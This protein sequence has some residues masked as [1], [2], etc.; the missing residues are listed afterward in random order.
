M[1]D[2][3]CGARG[4]VG[5]HQISKPL[6]S[7]TLCSVRRGL[8]NCR[9]RSGRFQ[10]PLLAAVMST[11]TAVSAAANDG[12]FDIGGG[13]RMYLE[14]RGSGSPTVVL[15]AGLKASADD[16][17]TAAKPGPAVFS[18]VANLTRVCAYDRP[19]TPVGGQAS[20]SDPVRQPT[21]AA[22]AVADLRALLGAA[23][24]AAP[25]VLVGHSYGGLI[26]TLYARFY[27]EAVAGLVLVDA[28]SEG[29]QQAEAPNQWAVQRVLL[30]GD[31]R[32]SLRLYPDLERID[33]D[34]S[35]D[36][37]RAAPPLKPIPLVVLSA[38]RPW[39]PQVPA[40]IANGMLPADVPR[41][42]AT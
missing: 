15:I 37:I 25:Y 26:A 28:L 22:G 7:G 16:W 13:R 32:E 29:L 19:G 1:P 35:F 6:S 39:G 3:P 23:H 30:E 12:F 2:E 31:I 41:T 4:A 14:C 5:V 24:E 33:P 17:N 36:E 42:S 20:R 27:P 34:R 10:L 21:T 40:L 11:L 8:G 38:D 9:S 18:G